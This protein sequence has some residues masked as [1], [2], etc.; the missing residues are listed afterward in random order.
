MVQFCHLG[1]ETVCFLSSVS[2]DG[3]D[4][5]WNPAL[6]L[7]YTGRF[8]TTIFSAIQHC[9]IVSNT[10]NIDPTLQRCVAPKSRRCK[11]S[12]VTSS[13]RTLAWYG[14]LVIAES[15]SC[16]WGT[17][18]LIFSLNLTPLIRTPR[19]CGQFFLSLGNVSPYIFSKFN[20]LDT[21]TSLLRTVFLVPGERKPLYFL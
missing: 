4:I 5:Q 15:F 13:L 18:A 2:T 10:F 7:C 11:S 8:A 12:R 1:K 6:R 17:K 16:P 9:N 20:S 19:Y 14:H 21:D 3:K